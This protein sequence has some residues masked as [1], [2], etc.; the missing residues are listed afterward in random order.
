[1]IFNSPLFIN[2]EQQYGV[3]IPRYAQF[4]TTLNPT[5]TS[6]TDGKLVKDADIQTALKTY[7]SSDKSPSGGT[8]LNNPSFFGL[9]TNFTNGYYFP[10][11]FGSNL[12][13][14]GQIT[15]SHVVMEILQRDHVNTFAHIIA[16]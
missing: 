2:V 5:F 11:H 7:I 9:G 10:I 15:P 1:M 8:V 6:I 12:F 13:T 4:K 14:L 16:I 3:G